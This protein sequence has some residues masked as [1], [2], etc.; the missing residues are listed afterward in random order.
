MAQAGVFYTL[1]V[2]LVLMSQCCLLSW[3]Q[4][5][6]DI[7]LVGGS[8]TN[9]GRVEV[10]FKEQWS[11][12]CDRNFAGVA[13]TVC[14]QLNHS[15][16][17]KGTSVRLMNK[18]LKEDGDLEISNM[19]DGA[20]IALMDMECG[21]IYSVPLVTTHILQCEYKSVTGQSECSH[22]DDLAVL[23]NV[24]TTVN[25]YNSEVRLVGGNFSSNGTLEI[26]LS[27]QWGNVC[28]EGFQQTTANTV[29]RQLGYTHAEHFKTEKNTTPIVWLKDV[30]CKATAHPCLNNCF[31]KHTVNKTTCSDDSFVA[32][33][34]SF[35]LI[36][37]DTSNFF[38]NAVMC[39]LQRKYSKTPAY[40]V[41][42][43]TVSS[44]FWIASSTVV[45][46]VA[47]CCTVKRCPCYKLKRDNT[48]AP[49]K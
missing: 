5:Q 43:V 1:G 47:V 15:Q 6:G 49:I 20:V 30:D 10:F 11:T 39:S 12:I 45:V 8:S 34:C 26:Y 7:R 21:P 18:S 4:S 40:F 35:E 17:L 33:Q 36:R 19:T 13:D 28:F 29:C 16:S 42:I 14:H 37:V 41:A 32:L 9:L 25:P 22:D 44:L 38:G 48:Y 24:E 2:I 31:G 23:C 27:E 46:I 3:A